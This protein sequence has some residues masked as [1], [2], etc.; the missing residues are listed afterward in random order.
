MNFSAQFSSNLFCIYLHFCLVFHSSPLAHCK[1][2][3]DETF[4]I[5]FVFMCPA[6]GEEFFICQ[7]NQSRQMPH[8]LH[9]FHRIATKLFGFLLVFAPVWGVLRDCFSISPESSKFNNLSRFDY[10]LA[11]ATICALI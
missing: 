3:E 8:V 10:P 4:V 2:N 9:Y 7:L 5:K 1:N 11:L 6:C